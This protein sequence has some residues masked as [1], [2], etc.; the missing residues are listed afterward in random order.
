M[1]KLIKL[2][3][4][5]NSLKPYRLATLIISILILGFIYLMAAIP[6]IEPNDSDAELFSS[7]D[8]VIGLTMVVLMGIFSVM[9]AV[10]SSKFVVD[11]YIGKKAILLFLYPIS[12]EKT[13]KAKIY[14]VFTYTFFSMFISGLAVLSAFLITESL[15]DINPD[16]ISMF[17]IVKSILS[18]ICYSLISAC[19]GI[20]SLWFGMVRKSVTVPIVASC[21]ISVLVCQIVAMSFFSEFFLILILILIII[22][23]LIATYNLKHRVNV[24]EV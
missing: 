8:F 2:E 4:K 12:R 13:L 5:K 11:E 22:F 14:L 7:Y 6:K 15:I 21:I 23:A 17:I 18:L 16:V 20:I 1:N 9:S 19:C 3:L 24:M 10:I